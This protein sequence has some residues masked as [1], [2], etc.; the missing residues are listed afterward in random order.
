MVTDAMLGS[1][2]VELEVTN[3]LSMDTIIFDLGRRWT[4]LV[5]G[6]QNY[7]SNISKTVTDTMMRSVEVE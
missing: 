2:E 3:V 5:Q 7:K 6:R 4:V 1:I